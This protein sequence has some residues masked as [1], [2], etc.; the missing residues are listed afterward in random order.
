MTDVVIAGGGPVGLSA[1]LYAA[2][3]GLSV[4]VYEPRAGA[5]DKACGEGLMPGAVAALADLGVRPEGQ[6]LRGIR[7]VAGSRR[8]EAYFDVGPGCGVRRTTLHSA[9]RAAVDMAAVPVVEEPITQVTQDSRG[10][11]ANGTRARYMI[12][13]DGLH[14]PVRRHLGLQAPTSSSRR[15][16]LR[17]H[18][19]TAPWTEFVE[20]H[21]SRWAEAYV[22]PVGPD[23][24]GIA[25]LTRRRA[26]FEEHLAAFAELH[27]HVRGRSMSQ[28]RGAGPLRQRTHRRVSGRV[29]LAGDA[30][31][32]VDALT[33]EGIA[34]GMAQ[35]REAVAAVADDQPQRY[36]QAW[37]R[38]TR[39][40]DV[41]TRSLLALTSLPPA[42]R[43][44][45]PLAATLPRPFS[46]V[47]NQLAHP[48]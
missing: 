27:A 15:F 7:Y 23:L 42:R 32:Y 19:Q 4:T 44:I 20:V 13:A 24:V 10:V 41:L 31:G 14:S 37:R 1:A 45:V 6:Q 35:A 22:T 40:Y 26:S 16:G 46:A 39:R 17:C 2:R 47:V 9:L 36:E 5:I 11:I 8:A 43:A 29:L 48:A 38:V 30:S 33:G 28:V 21:W 18:L 3:R 34:L 12:A 25:I